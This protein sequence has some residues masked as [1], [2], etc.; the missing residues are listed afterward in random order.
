MLRYL[1]DTDTL[2]ESGQRVPNRRIAERM[3]RHTGEIATAALVFREPLF[4]MNRLPPS[5]RRRDIERFVVGAVRT[6]IPILPYDAAAAAWHATERA[7]LVQA[8]LTPPFI[9]SQIAA[10]TPVNALT[11][12]TMNLRDYQHFD[13]L[14]V[15][16]W[17]A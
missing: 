6:R 3:S 10:V 4:G 8:G 15:K 11:L 12:V 7:R 2:S 17:S 9:D 16:D 13:G 5:R 14:Q 1:V